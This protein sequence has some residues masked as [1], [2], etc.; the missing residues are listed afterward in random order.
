MHKPAEPAAASEAPNQ[1]PLQEMGPPGKPNEEKEESNQ[2]AKAP[3]QD[4]TKVVLIPWMCPTHKQIMGFQLGRS[5]M[6][7]QIT[8]CGQKLKKLKEDNS[9]P[10]DAEEK[11]D[12][13]SSDSDS[14]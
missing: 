12:P 14:G 9:T 13:S 7:C 5:G 11:T 6:T 8:G 3:V 4:E 10:T 2:E 1:E